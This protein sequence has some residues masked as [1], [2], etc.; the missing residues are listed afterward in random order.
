[1]EE[2]KKYSYSPFV[3]QKSRKLAEKSQ[4]RQNLSP[5]ATTLDVSQATTA[6]LQSEEMDENSIATTA[7]QL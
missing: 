6:F 2:E 7:R 5:S 3:S 1:M 4:T